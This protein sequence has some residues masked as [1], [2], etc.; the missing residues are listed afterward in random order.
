MEQQLIKLWR[1]CEEETRNERS[2]EMYDENNKPIV[3]TFKL[4]FSDFIEWIEKK[5]IKK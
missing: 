5:L 3:Q 2:A 1:Q 4:Q